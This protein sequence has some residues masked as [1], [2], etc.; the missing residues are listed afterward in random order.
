MRYI[1]RRT[2][3]L[4]FLLLGVSLLSFFFLALAPG[5]FLDNLRLNPQISTETVAALRVQYGLDQSALMQYFHWLRSL[6]HG[7][8]GFSLAYNQ[9]AS[10]LLLPRARNTLLLTIT[11]AAVSWILSLAVGIWAATHRNRFLDRVISLGTTTLLGIPDLLL[12]LLL[13]LLAARTSILPVG[14]MVSLD[15]EAMSFTQKCTDLA[16]HMMLP[17]GALVLGALPTLVSHIRD[18][19]STALQEPFL[20]AGAGHGIS[21]RRLVLRY[22][23][24]VAAN[25]LISLIGFTVGA[26]LSGSLLVEMVLGWPGLG[27]LLLEAIMSRDIYLVIGAVM[28][29][30]F[31]LVGGTFLADLFLYW[32]DPRIRVG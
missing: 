22:A 5:N 10:A 31:F 7:D 4:G 25:P 16:A 30:S 24:P 26:L 1:L 18:A 9:Q 13:L 19:M 6:M 2:L 32:N 23:L 8:F 27:P 15:F 11:A 20:M 14:G 21:R 29:S 28:F 3:H 12:L 17:L